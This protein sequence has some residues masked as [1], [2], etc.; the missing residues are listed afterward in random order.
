MKVIR[1][2]GERGRLRSVG[3]WLVVALCMVVASAAVLVGARF[4][5]NAG[6]DEQAAP[7]ATPATALDARAVES[8]ARDV[9]G[10]ARLTPVGPELLLDT[11]ETEPV[12]AGAEVTVP[13]PGLPAG[14]GTVLVEVTILA[15]TKAGEV[16]VGSGA[17]ETTVLRVARARAQQ[18]ATV[19]ARL[20]D[21]RLRFGV[22]GGGDLLIQLVGVFET[23]QRSGAGRVVAVPATRVVRLVPRVDRKKTAFTLA[24]VPQLRRAGPIAAVL[25]RVSADVGRHGG[26]V[27]AGPAPSKLEQTVYWSATSGADR[28]R[29]GLLFVPVTGGSVHMRY[30]AGTEMRADLVGYVTG[31]GAT[32]EVAGL[33]VPLPPRGAEPVRVAARGGVDLDL[34][35]TARLAGV[36]ADR[37]AASLLTVT[38][39]GDAVGGVTVRGPGAAKPKTPTLVA[40]KSGAR[41]ELTLV[42]AAS[43]KVRVDSAVGADITVTPLA[44]VLTG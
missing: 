39:R 29:G 33:V 21:G 5:A 3:R 26:F 16:T 2:K 20:E 18:S 12:P 30:E 42:P 43:G 34:T 37:I 38:A 9:P 40:P 22:T 31:D 19:V 25:L 10:S 13:V 35:A 11:R 1:A 8:A 44:L 14:V 6:T 17:E 36:P 28:T 23:A 27:K 7:P 15:A 32:E 24:D 4:A 41:P